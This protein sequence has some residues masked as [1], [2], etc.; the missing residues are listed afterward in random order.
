MEDSP[1]DPGPSVDAV[2]DFRTTQW[3]QVL[4]A[5][6]G[7]SSGAAPALEQLC[8]TYW[9]PLYFFVRRRGCTPEDAEDI[10]QDFFTQLLRLKSLEAVTPHKGKFRTFLLASLKHFLLNARD[11]A[12]AA[13][14]GGGQALISLDALGAEQRYQLEPVNE[15]TPE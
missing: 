12:S 4:A 14:R 3:S 5:G 9:Y 2:A 15:E 7:G 1:N 10:T 6:Q 8:R 11:A 13:K